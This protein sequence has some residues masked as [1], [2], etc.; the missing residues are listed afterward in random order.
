MSLIERKAG[1][2][3]FTVMITLLGCKKTKEPTAPIDLWRPPPKLLPFEIPTC[4]TL[5]NKE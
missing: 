1:V 2:I 5:I 4:S 3:A